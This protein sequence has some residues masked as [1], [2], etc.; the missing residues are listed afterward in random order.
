[1]KIYNEFQ[2]TGFDPKGYLLSDQQNWFVLPCGQNRDSN[3]LDRSN[4][5]VALE[6]LG[7]ESENV[8]VHRF[9]HW[10]YGWFEIIIINPESKQVQIACDIENQL[11]QYPILDDMDYSEL[12]WNEGQNFWCSMSIRERVELCQEYGISAL[13]AR[14]NFIPDCSALEDYLVYSC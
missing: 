9:G 1:M 11:E 10:A 2:P 5:K 3:C 4:F 13:K 6:K 14:H 12:Q 7:G 8:E